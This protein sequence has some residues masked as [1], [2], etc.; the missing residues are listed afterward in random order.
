MVYDYFSRDHR[1][2]QQHRGYSNFFQAPTARGASVGKCGTDDLLLGSS[3]VLQAVFAKIGQNVISLSVSLGD[4][5]T[6]PTTTTYSRI[7]D[8]R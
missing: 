5:Y 2:K 1:A 6:D 8:G 4:V 7:T 3:L